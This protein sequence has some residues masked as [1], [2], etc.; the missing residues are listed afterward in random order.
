MGGTGRPAESYGWTRETSRELWM[1]QGDQ[2]VCSRDTKLKAT[3]SETWRNKIGHVVSAPNEGWE[4]IT[5]KLESCSLTQ[6]GERLII[7]PHKI[8][9]FHN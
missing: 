7:T 6:R 9:E 4:K 3:F 8:N 5:V 1:D 2:S